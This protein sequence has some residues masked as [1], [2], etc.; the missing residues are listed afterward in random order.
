MKKEIN[1]N[2]HQ[3]RGGNTGDL[4]TDEVKCQTSDA[5]HQN[6][7]DYK[8]VAVIVQVHLLNHFQSADGD[9]TIQGNANSADNTDR[10]GIDKCHKRREERTEKAENGSQNDRID[11][12]VTGNCHTADCF[13]VRGIRASAEKRPQNRAESVSQKRSVKTRIFDQ[14]PSDNRAEVLM[15]GNMLR[16]HDQRHRGEQEKDIGNSYSAAQRLCSVFQH[17]EERK[18]WNTEEA[19]S[20]KIPEIICQRRI[21]DNLQ[22]GNPRC[23]TDCCK[24]RRYQISCKNTNDKRNHPDMTASVNRSRN[25]NQKSN[26][27][28]ENGN[29][30]IVTAGRIVQVADCGGTKAQSDQG[31]RGADNNRRHKPVHPFCS[32]KRDNDGKNDIDR[33]GKNGSQKDSEITKRA[34]ADQGRDKSKGASQEN[35]TAFLCTEHIQKSSRPCPEKRRGLAHGYLCSPGCSQIDQ[36]RNQQ[37]CRDNGKKLLE[38][39]HQIFLKR[40]LL[41]YGIS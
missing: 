35:R 12:R 29:Q 14:V 21:I 32:D 16:K 22:I 25:R 4:D 41:L 40:R 5:E 31:N 38:R 36:R 13:P 19:C 18:L 15:V 9:K 7:A 33:T 27:A 30:V 17:S 23:M 6:G 28:T 26:Q 10:N 24:D 2:S 1:Q 34:G 20:G 11:G 8:Q 37:G 3:Q 39:I